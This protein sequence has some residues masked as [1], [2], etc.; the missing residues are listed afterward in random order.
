[1]NKERILEIL[2]TLKDPIDA[3]HMVEKYI[4]LNQNEDVIYWDINSNEVAPSPKVSTVHKYAD[5]YIISEKTDPFMTSKGT[6]EVIR[7]DFIFSNDLLSQHK[8]LVQ[9]WIHRKQIS[10][11]NKINVY[12]NIH[13][14]TGTVSIDMT[15]MKNFGGI[16]ARYYIEYGI[17][18]MLLGGF[19]W[20]NNMFLTFIFEAIKSSPTVQQKYL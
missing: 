14:Q 13:P 4:Y 6:L 2:P 1:M 16:S 15:Q 11:G 9:M 12:Y 19:I 20:A 7:T 8:V 17:Y 3:K 5:R 18:P 10:D